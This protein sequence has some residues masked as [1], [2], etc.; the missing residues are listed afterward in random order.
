[1]AKHGDLMASFKKVVEAGFN[2]EDPEHKML[3][4][5]MIMKSADISNE[6]RPTDV[7]EPWVDCLLEEFFTQSDREKAEGLPYAPFMD[8]EKVTKATAQVGFIQFVMVPLFEL[9][10]KVLPNME[11]PIIKPIRQALAY[12]KEL[13]EK[14]KKEGK[15]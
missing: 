10:S 2:L 9:V 14:E 3:L 4:L 12:Y 11:E 15:A 8:R 5:Q 13:Q 6:V 7:A 1:M